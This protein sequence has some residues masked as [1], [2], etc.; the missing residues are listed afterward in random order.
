LS[1]RLIETF[2]AAARLGS[3]SAAGKAL[4]LSP[5][6]VSQNIKNLED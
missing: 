2:V 1:L 6:S 5:G 4:G 3:F